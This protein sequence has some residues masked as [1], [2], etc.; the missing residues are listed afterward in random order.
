[1][2]LAL[3]A[4]EAAKFLLPRIEAKDGV[5][6]LRAELRAFAESKGVPL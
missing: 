1:M 6:S 5:P 4:G 2:T 3:D